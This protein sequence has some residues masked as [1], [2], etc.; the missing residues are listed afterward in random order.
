MTGTQAAVLGFV[1]AG[2]AAGWWVR[3][4]HDSAKG[5]PLIDG[6]TRNS[7]ELTHELDRFR[8]AA[9][10]LVAVASVEPRGERPAVRA[11]GRVLE[12]ELRRLA[13]LRSTISRSLG[14]EHPVLRQLGRLERVAADLVHSATTDP[15]SVPT[16]GIEISVATAATRAAV[17]TALFDGTLR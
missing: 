17:E 10:A 11:A 12:A 8:R 2:F 14:D 15:G 16:T 13:H 9:L 3:G 6:G 1:L 4:N 5:H 7:D